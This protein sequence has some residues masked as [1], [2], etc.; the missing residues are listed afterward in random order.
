V[1]HNSS[2]EDF[3][4]LSNLDSVGGSVRINYNDAL[5][6]LEGLDNID[7]GSITALSIFLN[8]S[9]SECYTQSVCNYLASPNGTVSISN[10]APGCNSPEEVELV[11]ETVGVGQPAVGGQRSA[12]RIYPNPASSLITVECDELLTNSTFTIYNLQGQEMMRQRITQ[13]KSVIDV[14]RL[15]S[16][17]YFFLLTSHVSHLT[18]T[19]KLV[20]S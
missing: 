4:G 13:A 14:S 18:T 2:L 10:N 16:G 12:V 11:C 20:K 19:G 6:S 1:W 3:S 15:P 9:L 8:P 17:M 5:T 7:A